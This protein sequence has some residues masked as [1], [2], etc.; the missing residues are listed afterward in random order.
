M[1]PQG[2]NFLLKDR[3]I[4]RTKSF[5]WEGFFVSAIEGAPVARPDP[6]V[7]LLQ[8]AS[9]TMVKLLRTGRSHFRISKVLYAEE[10]GIIFG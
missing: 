2:N 4:F 8:P 9:Q 7:G 6:V 1:P 10:I 5:L 3:M